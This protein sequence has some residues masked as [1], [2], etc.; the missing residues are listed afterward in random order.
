MQNT[1]IKI[2][3]HLK[4]VAIHSC[5]ILIQLRELTING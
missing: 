4:R 2:A 5:E 3:V 1:V